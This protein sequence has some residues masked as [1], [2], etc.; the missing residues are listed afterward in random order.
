LMAGLVLAVACLN[1]ANLLLARGSAR[2]KE[3]A[4]RQALGSGRRR[5]I[6]QLIIEGLTL[7]TIGAACGLLASWWT[8]A[9]LAAWLSSVVT[10]GIDFVVEPSAR[11][12][13]ALFALLSTVLFALGPAWSLS[14]IDV[15]SDLKLA[16]GR[17]TGRLAS[18]SVL[19]V[20]QL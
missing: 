15:T 4:L 14:R 2:R 8:A 7:S 6:Q 12:A 19:V 5:I 20:L 17:L 3:M 13:A 16:P 9:G 11:V 18:G 1:L 10:F